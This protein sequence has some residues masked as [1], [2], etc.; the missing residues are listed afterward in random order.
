MNANKIIALITAGQLAVDAHKAEWAAKVM[1]GEY[2]DKIR[3]YED[4]WGDLQCKINRF[5]DE[6]EHVRQFTQDAF[7]AHRAAKRVAYNIK[8]RLENACRKAAS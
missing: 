7:E 2:T 3:E 4:Q 6:F 8:R 5:D 1:Y